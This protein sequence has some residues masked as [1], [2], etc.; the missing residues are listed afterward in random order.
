MTFHTR[1]EA[2]AGPSVSP[3]PWP[4][5]YLRLS[6]CVL[7]YLDSAP[8]PA[9]EGAAAARPI[10]LIHGGHGAWIHWRANLA[11]LASRHRVI[12]PDMPGFG[13]SSA[14]PSPGIDDIAAE[15]SGWIDQ[16]GLRDLTIAGFSFGSLVTTALSAL[17]PDAISRVLLINPP[18]LG[19]RSP[20][21]ARLHEEIGALARASGL[22][23]GVSAT[24]RRLMLADP[25]QLTEAM[26]DD[27]EYAV[28]R[29][30]FVTRDISR[31][32]DLLP[33]LAALSQPLRV[34]IGEQDPYHRH[35]IAGRRERVAQARGEDCVMVFPRAAHWLQYECRD[36]F[37]ATLL[38]F[39]SAKA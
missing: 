25:A 21:A 1:P 17:R 2:D 18:G 6:R 22:R 23:E 34:L 27:F 8:G 14:L 13:A 16:L 5:R 19:K 39:A 4:L 29:T 26:L 32:T 33:A 10:L 31:A 20:E 36:E 30:R 7:G 28:R 15:L 37:A 24:L 11:A 9:A 12:V 38:A 35:D 3:P